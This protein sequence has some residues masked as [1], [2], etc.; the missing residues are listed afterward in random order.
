MNVRLKKV[1]KNDA[2]IIV[3]WRNE[4]KQFFPEQ[5]DFTVGS[6]N[7]WFTN[8]YMYDPTDHYYIVSA[9]G[10]PVGTIAIDSQSGQIGRVLLGNKNFAR[11]GVMSEALDLLTSTHRG[12]GSAW[13]RVL[14][15]NTGAIEFYERNGFKPVRA[16]YQYP[17]MLVMELNE[18]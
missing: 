15:D 5:P 13:L 18:R 12:P 6:Q 2:G 1:Q 9:D 3:K 17:D 10:T 14:K 16:S 11:K 7:H 4:N 8:T